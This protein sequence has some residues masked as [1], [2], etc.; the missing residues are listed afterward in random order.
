MLLPCGELFPPLLLRPASLLSDGQMKAMILVTAAVELIHLPSTIG[1]LGEL[2]VGIQGAAVPAQRGGA[3]AVTTAEALS[4]GGKAVIDGMII[5]DR[6]PELLQV[7]DALSASGRFAG[8]LNGRK[9]QSDQNGND[10]DDDEQ[11]DQGKTTFL[12]C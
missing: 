2:G 4:A 7:V 6:Q 3:T 12:R 10:R 5:V 8:R 11:L 9:K 1:P